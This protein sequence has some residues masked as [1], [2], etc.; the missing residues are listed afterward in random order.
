MWRSR[1][2]GEGKD[3][4]SSEGLGGESEWKEGVEVGGQDE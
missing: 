1:G 2:K 3:V 4:A